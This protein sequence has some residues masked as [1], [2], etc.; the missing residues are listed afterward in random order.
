MVSEFSGGFDVDVV[1][2]QG[3][4][5]SVPPSSGFGVAGE[6]GIFAEFGA[7]FAFERGGRRSGHFASAGYGY[8][9]FSETVLGAPE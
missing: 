1:N 9:L 3:F 5:M 7:G 4:G 2:G 6:V 8:S